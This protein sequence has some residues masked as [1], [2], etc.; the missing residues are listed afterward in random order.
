MCTRV[1]WT[2]EINGKLYPIC[3]RNMD[4][5]ANTAEKLWVF[6]AGL[7]RQSA[8]DYLDGDGKTQRL[9]WISKYGS[10]VLSMY[11]QAVADGMNT[12]GLAIHCNWLTESYYGERDP[13]NQGLIAIEWCHISSI[14]LPPSQ[15]LLNTSAIMKICKLSQ[16]RSTWEISY[17]NGKSK[18]T[19]R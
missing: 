7:K 19:W 2:G 17:R 8:V 11:D 16:P 14:T 13:K 4:W 18:I 3:G 15:K 12:E 6:P 9:A 10:I 5:G 1:L